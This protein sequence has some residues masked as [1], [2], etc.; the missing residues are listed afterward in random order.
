MEDDLIRIMGDNYSRYDH[1]DGIPWDEA[2]IPRRWHRCKVQTE[3]WFGF[4]QYLKC[5]CGA[6]RIDGGSW[7]IKN[8]RRS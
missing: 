7:T 3:A 5:A 2:P 6:V 1:K 4:R 8:S